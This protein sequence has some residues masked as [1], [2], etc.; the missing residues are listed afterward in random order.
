MRIGILSDS[1]LPGLVRQLDELGPEPGAFFSTVDLILH[2]GD[3]T[4][5]TVLDWLEQFAPLLCSTGNNDP[6]SDIRSKNI[7]MLE[8]EG[9]KIGCSHRLA[10]LVL[11]LSRWNEQAT[12][13]ALLQGYLLI[14]TSAGIRGFSV[15]RF[16]RRTRK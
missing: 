8:Q 6:I 14:R 7:Q 3:V 12:G 15:Y 9:W 11:H 10:I 1:H 4:S 13:R 16:V 2:S 5:P